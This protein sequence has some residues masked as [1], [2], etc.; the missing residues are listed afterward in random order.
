MY[1]IFD[2]ET[3]SLQGGVC[4]LAYIRV[5]K[6]LNVLEEFCSYVN[7]ER[8]IEDGARAI[9]GITDDKVREAPTLADLRD[10]NNPLFAPGIVGVGHNVSFD[11]RML[12]GYVS[13]SVALCTLKLARQH[14]N[15]PSNKLEDLQTA[16][17]LPK[18]KSHSA[19]GDVHTC[20]DC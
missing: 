12:K 4:E 13:T 15:Q 19:L 11:L 16:L 1:Y 10:A 2:T 17:G 14:L 8:K 3:A 18:Q 7:P 6:D 5:D 9:H 20:R